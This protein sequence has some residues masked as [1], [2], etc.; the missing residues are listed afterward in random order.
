MQHGVY[1]QDTHTL[2]SM[3]NSQAL[4][5]QSTSAS[6]RPDTYT[7]Q[8]SDPF[9]STASKTPPPSDKENIRSSEVSIKFL[10]RC[11]YTNKILLLFRTASVKRLPRS[12]PEPAGGRVRV[13]NWGKRSTEVRP[14][15]YL[16][17]NQLEGVLL[18]C[19]G[20][21]WNSALE[22]NECVSQKMMTRFAGQTGERED[23]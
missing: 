7:W 4:M 23:A 12:L 14:L 15:L 2:G 10:D 11:C 5:S 13:L 8:T 18:H 9:L 17:P 21:C 16:V 6:S 22:I 3:T 19:S 1:S 20:R